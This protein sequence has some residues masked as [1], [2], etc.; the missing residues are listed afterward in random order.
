MDSSRFEIN[1]FLED[2][3]NQKRDPLK[4]VSYR[5]WSKE[6]KRKLTYADPILDVSHVP[7]EVQKEV[8]EKIAKIAKCLYTEIK[9]QMSLFSDLRLD[10][11]DIQD[12]ATHLETRYNANEVTPGQLTTVAS[13]MNY[14]AQPNDDTVKSN[15]TSSSSSHWKSCTQADPIRAKIQGKTIPEAF[16]KVACQRKKDLACAD[17]ITKEMTY[18]R[19]MLGII[20]LSKKI[21]KV[22]G[23]YVGVLLPASIAVNIVIIACQVA[24]KIPVMI[25]W[26]VGKKHLESVI[27]QTGLKYVVS[28]NSFLKKYY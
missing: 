25:N 19:L 5:F 23:K 13:V 18:E 21:Q 3:Y 26:T 17:F 7:E 20:L 16:F 1:R 12:L 15:E 9:P 4:L 2:W 27:E 22:P 6:V 14:A 8:R 24:N 28:S 11:L 10:S